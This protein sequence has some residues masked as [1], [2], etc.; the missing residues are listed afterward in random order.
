MAMAR[1]STVQVYDTRPVVRLCV[2]R[3]N[4]GGDVVEIYQSANALSGM[5]LSLS[6][7]ETDQLIKDLSSALSAAHTRIAN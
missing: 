7:M 6:L 1:I 2:H 5:S 3:D 4:D